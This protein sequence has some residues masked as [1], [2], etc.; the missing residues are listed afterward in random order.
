MYQL[1]RGEYDMCGWMNNFLYSPLGNVLALNKMSLS[2]TT[3]RAEPREN[4]I[5]NTEAHESTVFVPVVETCCKNI[6]IIV[7]I[8]FNWNKNNNR[9]ATMDLIKT[10]EEN[11]EVEDFSEDSDAEVEVIENS[12]KMFNTIFLTEDS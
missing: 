4:F 10:I 8:V 5:H 6:Q 9:V 3:F 11:A 2:N 12:S 7:E 1:K